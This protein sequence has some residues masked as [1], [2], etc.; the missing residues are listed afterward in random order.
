MKMEPKRVIVLTGKAGQGHFSIAKAYG[1]W[2][3]KWGY[4]VELAD[5]LPSLNDKLIN[6]L[7]KTP[8]TYKSLFEFSNKPSFAEIMVESTHSQIKKNIL[9]TIPNY[10]SF[11]LVISTYPLI[12]PEGSAKK[13]MILP[14]PIAHAAY[15]SAPQPDYYFAFWSKAVEEAEKFEVEDKKILLVPPLAR[16]AFYEIGEKVL[17]QKKRFK[18]S[19]KKK[20]GIPHDHLLA[21]VMAGSGW[22]YRTDDYLQIL[23][24][25]FKDEQV[26]FCFVCGRNQKWQEEKASE[27][28]GEKNFRFLGWLSEE[29]MAQWMAAADFGLAFSLAQMSVE[30]GLVG[31]PLFIFRL[32]EGQEEG[33]QEEIERKGV[34][35]FIPGEPENQVKVF[36]TMIK[37]ESSL[38]EKNLLLWQKEL[39]AGPVKVKRLISAITKGTGQR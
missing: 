33:Y 21:L 29:E 19:L 15:F 17:K 2:L 25:S 7:Y 3:K 30:A 22:V 36:K 5:V 8:Q 10:S 37:Q 13:I 4:L 26:I 16:Q 35:M 12:H 9:K 6:F 34:G 32:I 1:Y 31:L 38:F 23:R 20:L 39:L 28:S 11:D 18:N 14:D 27:Y 24:D